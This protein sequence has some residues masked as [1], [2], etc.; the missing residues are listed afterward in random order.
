[1]FTN[2]LRFFR[3]KFQNF[4]LLIQKHNETFQRY[5]R[6]ATPWG[7]QNKIGFLTHRA[8]HSAKTL[9]QKCNKK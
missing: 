8:T 6:G 7:Q 3:N 1:M 2:V 9:A 4:S 5:L